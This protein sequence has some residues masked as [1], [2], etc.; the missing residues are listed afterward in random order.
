MRG[1]VT[2]I[3]KKSTNSQSSSNIIKMVEC[4]IKRTTHIAGMRWKT[5]KHSARITERKRPLVWMTSQRNLQR[6]A[7][8]RG[9]LGVKAA[10]N[11]NPPNWQQ[12]LSSVKEVCHCQSTELLNMNLTVFKTEHENLYPINPIVPSVVAGE[13]KWSYGLEGNTRETRSSGII[14]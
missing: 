9:I 8:W 2:E 11:K 1:E 14:V 12:A 6:M 5:L 7:C 13:Y 10:W 4:R 3:K